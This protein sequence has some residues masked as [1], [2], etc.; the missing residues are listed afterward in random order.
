MGVPMVIYKDKPKQHSWCR[1]MVG[2]VMRKNNNNLV[3]WIGKTGS[4]KTFSA[5][6]AAE[7]MSEMSGVPFSVDNIVFSL[8]E[9]M[10]LI[11]SGKLKRGS[12]IIFDEPQ[13]SISSKDFQSAANK[14]FNLLVTTFRHRNYSLFFCTPFESLLDKSTRRLF[15]ARFETLSIN[16]NNKTCRLKPRWVEYSDFKANPYIKQLIVCFKDEE[17]ISRSRKLF[18]W[19]VPIPSQEIID[20][21]E[22]KK[23]EFTTRLNANIMATLEKFDASGKSMTAEIK[24]VERKPLTQSQE[25]AMRAI[26]NGGLQHAK[27]ILGISLGSI[28]QSKKL[29]MKK[30]YT[31]EE[32]KDA[33]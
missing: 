17:K 31:L 5:I 30:G 18:H 24:P 6:S 22:V 12:T 8:R 3:S 20:A 9:L 27:E 29:A 26:A 14:V 33:E 23:M 1:F 13:A 7:I 2:R 28:H 21:Y 16:P 10:E 11:N 32:F 15:H 4:G 25:D 19:D